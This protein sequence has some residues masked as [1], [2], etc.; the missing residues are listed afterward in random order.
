MKQN[1]T[2]VIPEG[3]VIA[4]FGGSFDPPHLAHQ[5]IPFFLLKQKLVDQVWFVPVKH[6]PF[7]KVV[8]SDEQRLAMLGAVLHNFTHTHFEFR[9]QLRIETCEI[10]ENHSSYTANTLDLLAKQHPGV[11]FR[12]VIG[13]DNLEKFHLWHDYKRIAEQYG[14]FVY[15]RV[16]YPP[17]PL[18]PGMQFLAD[19]PE[20][21]VSSTLV[22]RKVRLNEP[23]STFVLPEVAD[24][25]SKHH[26]YQ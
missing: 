24:Y 6:H 17:T 10:D 11:Q 1:T 19:A 18:I 5:H 26:L 25:M 21:D 8:S 13:S 22:R 23:I 20:V 9:D 2:L 3:T 15:P 16:G 14:I 4:L 12:W 7:G